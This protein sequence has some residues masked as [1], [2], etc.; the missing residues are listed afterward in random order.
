M[1]KSIELNIDQAKGLLGQ[2]S[3]LDVLLKANFTPIEL[4]LKTQDVFKSFA[5]VLAF[6]NE[7]A[8]QFAERTA[9]D[10]PDEVGYKKCKMIVYALN[11][12]KYL[13]YKD[14]GVY[15][16]YPWFNSAGSGSGFSFF[17]YA[18]VYVRSDV[19]S[20]LLLETSALAEYAGK[21]FTAEYNE[22][23]NG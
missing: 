9:N 16:Y 15:K 18:Y 17:V 20:R 2:N 14:A 23:I 21:T 4:G 13:D 7:T 5:D 12:G 22:F 10:T 6:H 19:V 1:K 3:A 11:G 8:E